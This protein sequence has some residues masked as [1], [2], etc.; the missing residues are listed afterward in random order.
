M[1]IVGCVDRIVFFRH[2]CMPRCVAVRGAATPTAAPRWIMRYPDQTVPNLTSTGRDLTRHQS[3]AT[4]RSWTISSRSSRRLS[5]D[6]RRDFGSFQRCASEQNS[7]CSF[8][9]QLVIS[10]TP[11]RFI[12]RALPMSRRRMRCGCRRQPMALNGFVS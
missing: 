2:N 3:M 1:A 9:Q 7:W 5:L 8:D 11:R 12:W 10:S 4:V 6:S